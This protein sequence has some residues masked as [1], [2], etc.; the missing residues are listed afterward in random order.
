MADL[1]SHGVDPDLVFATFSAKPIVT[2]DIS[3]LLKNISKMIEKIP[4]TS[5]FR[6][7]LQRELFQGKFYF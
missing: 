1:L 5:P 3:H 6:T 2:G 4:V 7:T